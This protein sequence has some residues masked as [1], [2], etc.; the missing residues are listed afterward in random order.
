M[1]VAK[2]LVVDDEPEMLE[3]L[4]DVLEDE[5]YKVLTVNN[6]V[7]AIAKVKE[8][9]PEVVLLD[10]KMSDMDGMEV[11]HWI[12]KI[13][14]DIPIIMIT[15]YGSMDS[16]IQAMKLGAYDY[17]PKPFDLEKMKVLVKRALEA[18]ILTEQIA[19][20]KL[21]LKEKYKLENIVGKDPKMYEVYKTIG[22]VV[23]NKATVLIQGET[24]TGKELVARAIHFNSIVK[25]GPFIAIDCAS[26]PQDLLESELFGHEKGAFT[27]A[28][29]KKLGKFESANNGTLFLDEVGNLTSSIQAKLL[30]AL[31]EKKIERVGGIKPIKIDTRII[32]ATNMNLEELVKRRLF[33]EDLYY[34]LNVVTIYLPPLRERRDDIPLLVEHFLRK[35][36]SESKGRVKYV[37]PETMDLLIRYEWPGNVRELENVIERAVIIGKTDAILFEDLPLKIQKAAD[38]SIGNVPRGNL[39]LKKMV[40]DFEKKMIIRALEEANWVQTRAAKLLDINRRVIRYKMQKYG[41]K[42]PKMSNYHKLSISD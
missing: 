37:P 23:D 25:E 6:G 17:L 10:I 3:T 12:K 4:S 39:S 14:K 24:G 13:N 7:R 2:I 22:K 42:C 33:R 26:L 31:Q 21:K 29:A 11:L 41:I 8:E 9:K 32:A 19:S 18:R 28:V 34:R 15:G 1:S 36:K 38:I 27:G 16:V 30:R 40:A 5:G 20:L 35:Y